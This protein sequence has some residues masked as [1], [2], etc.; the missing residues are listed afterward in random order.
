VREHERATMNGVIP[1]R[2]RDRT[3]YEALREIEDSLPLSLSERKRNL[4]SR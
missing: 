1:R 3:L 2:P 4:S